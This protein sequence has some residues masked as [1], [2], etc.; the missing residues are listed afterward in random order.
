MVWG[1]QTTEY[2]DKTP[3]VHDL[4]SVLFDPATDHVINNGKRRNTQREAEEA[5]S[6]HQKISS[7]LTNDIH[8]SLSLLDNLFKWHLKFRCFKSWQQRYL[9]L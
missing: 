4:C 7:L 8:K 3:K 9:C 2:P 5:I 6:P 1:P